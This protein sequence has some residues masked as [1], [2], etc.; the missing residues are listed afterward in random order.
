MKDQ[1]EHGVI[2]KI[3]SHPDLAGKEITIATELQS[4]GIDSLEFTDILADLEKSYDIRI[5]LNTIDAWTDLRTVGDL[6]A[7]VR[8]LLAKEA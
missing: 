6:V 2:E 8:G 4:L 1:L 3:K 7:S 5:E